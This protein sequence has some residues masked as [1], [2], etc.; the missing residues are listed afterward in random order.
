MVGTWVIFA[1][2]LK[3]FCKLGGLRDIWHKMPHSGI[4]TTFLCIRHSIQTWEARKA[5]RSKEPPSTTQDSLQSPEEECTDKPEN[6]VEAT[7]KDH[8][9]EYHSS[10][11]RAR[12]AP[13]VAALEG[14]EGG[15]RGEA[16]H[17]EER[18]GGCWPHEAEEAFGER[19]RPQLPRN[20]QPRRLQKET[21][22]ENKAGGIHLNLFIL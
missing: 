3:V 7:C 6:H 19:K 1:F 18:K 8:A 20:Q 17:E 9:W 22:E 10:P 13:A 2:G 21:T 15:S 11:G 12:P 4:T 5:Q 14:W 16:C